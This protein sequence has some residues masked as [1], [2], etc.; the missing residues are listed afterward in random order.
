MAERLRRSTRNR[1]GFSRVGSSPAGVVTFWSSHFLFSRWWWLL[2]DPTS[3]TYSLTL[4]L[5]SPI[6]HLISCL[7]VSFEALARDNEDAGVRNTDTY[8]QRF[9]LSWQHIRYWYIRVILF[10][11]PKRIFIYYS[12]AQ[13]CNNK[14]QSKDFTFRTH[15]ISVRYHNSINNNLC[16]TI[17]ILNQSPI[18]Y[19]TS[20]ADLDFD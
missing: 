11:A 1:L 10:H 14:R 15:L 12:M 19:S 6:S 17:S 4:F 8:L 3:V 9:A 20:C 18:W 16:S 13:N 5:L 2:D 7:F